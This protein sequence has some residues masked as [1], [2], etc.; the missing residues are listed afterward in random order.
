MSHGRLSLFLDFLPDKRAEKN[1]QNGLE[2]RAVDVMNAAVWAASIVFGNYVTSCNLRCPGTN[3]VLWSVAF[4]QLGSPLLL[5]YSLYAVVRPGLTLT[6]K[7]IM[8]VVSM[9]LAVCVVQPKYEL[10]AQPWP[11]FR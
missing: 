3:A 9:W 1:Y 2:L 5:P 8:H 6:A 4:I 7:H 11:M 10:T